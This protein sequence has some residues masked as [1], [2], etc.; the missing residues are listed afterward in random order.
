[1]ERIIRNSWGKMLAFVMA[2]ALAFVSFIALLPLTASAMVAEIEKADIYVTLPA[3][4][5]KASTVASSDKFFY[6]IDEFDEEVEIQNLDAVQ[7]DV[8]EKDDNGTYVAMDMESV[9]KADGTYKLTIT[10]SA[11][12]TQTIDDYDTTG[13]DVNIVDI[14]DNDVKLGYADWDEAEKIFVIEDIVFNTVTFDSAGGS[15]VEPQKV[16]KGGYAEWPGIPT[17]EG[18]FCA[19]WYTE[20]GDEL[21]PFGTFQIEDDITFTAKWYLSHTVISGDNQTFY[22]ASGD[23]VV[24][25]FDANFAHFK[26]LSLYNDDSFDDVDLSIG[27]YSVTEGSTVLTLSNSLLKTLDPGTYSV[28]LEFLDP[29]V[30]DGYSYATATLYVVEGA[31]PSTSPATPQTSDNSNV[32]AL[33]GIAGAAAVGLTVIV[34]YR[35]KVTE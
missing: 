29:D 14:N 35:K 25:S 9:F 10:L 33:A 32:I 30:D 19:G 6:I 7:I 15:A 16:I 8:Y 3:V 28:I 26:D 18:Y 2:F 13:M 5:A 17:K 11:T 1:M 21:E 24:I 4:G 12:D 23:D 20:A 27:G 22:L 31:A 34:A